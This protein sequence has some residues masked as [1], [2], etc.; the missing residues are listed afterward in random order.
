MAKVSRDFRYMCAPG[1]VSH[2][3]PM[4]YGAYTPLVVPLASGVMLSP[5]SSGP[6]WHAA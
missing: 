4:A 3:A 1:Q 2:L 5:T 6:V